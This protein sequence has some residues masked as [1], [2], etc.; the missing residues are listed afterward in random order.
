MTTS[1]KI[2]VLIACFFIVF[3]IY[4]QSMK[5][6][7]VFDDR[8]ILDHRE[9]L[10]GFE[11]IREAVMYPF[12]DTESGL[13]RPV[14]LI[15]YLVNFGLGPEPINFHFVNL[16]LYIFTCLLIF[17][18]INQISKNEKLGWIVA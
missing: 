10:T 12:W 1:K 14:T 6:G 2:L 3:V 15:S 17:L 16:V 5:G 8:N 4:G 13:Y 11:N 9:I 7:F 18:F